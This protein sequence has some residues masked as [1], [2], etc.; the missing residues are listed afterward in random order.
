MRTIRNEPGVEDQIR[1]LGIRYERF[2]ELMETVC[3]TLCAHPDTF[4][5]LAGTR[6]SLC[7]TNE[8][9]GISF[10]DIP[11]LSIYFHYDA[12]MVY[13]LA[14]EE[15]ALESYG[16]RRKSFSSNRCSVVLSLRKIAIAT[17][18]S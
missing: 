4:P 3:E 6:L 2:D 13:I 16:L 12:D 9:A 18:S 15:C 8:F 11:R 10:A 5:V 1:N 14:V 7:R 17:L